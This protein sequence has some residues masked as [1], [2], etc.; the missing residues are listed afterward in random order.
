M[1]NV[2]KARKSEIIDICKS[3][4]CDL[5]TIPGIY[6]IIEGKVDIKKIRDV[7]IEDLL[8]RETIKVNTEEMSGYIEEKTISC[9]WWRR[10]YRI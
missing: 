2:D 5:K 8:G 7:D 10:I 3:C 4:K 1:A 9:Y 6:E